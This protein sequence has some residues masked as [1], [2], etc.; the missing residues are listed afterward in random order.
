MS[1]SITKLGLAL[2]MITLFALIASP[3][4]AQ[5]PEPPER[6]NSIGLGFVYKFHALRE[7]ESATGE[8]VP[9]QEMLAGFGIS[10]ER[11]LIPKHLSISIGKPFLFNS[12]RFDSPLEI[13]VR[14]LFRKGAWE[15][16][17]GLGIS[18]NLRAFRAEREEAEGTRVEYSIG[19]VA[20]TGFSYYF[21]PKWGLQLEVAYIWNVWV[22]GGNGF[23]HELATALDGVFYF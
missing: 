14:A 15:P 11:V 16:F 3:V 1:L 23:E 19:V 17:V 9:E 10:Y 22:S 20:I 13:N 8:P 2:A 4:R 7:R 12:E 18:S 6:R 5:E 21:T